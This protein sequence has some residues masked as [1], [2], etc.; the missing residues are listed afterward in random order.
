MKCWPIIVSDFTG[1]R[2]LLCMLC[3]ALIW[4]TDHENCTIAQTIARS[5]EIK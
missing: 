1:G 5:L 2:V 3:L 4:K